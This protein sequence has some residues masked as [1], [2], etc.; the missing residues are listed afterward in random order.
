MVQI[1]FHY[2]PDV[3]REQMIGYE[4]AALIWGQ[5]FT[6]N[7]NVDIL[8]TTTNQLNENVIGG[9]SPQFHEQH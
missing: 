2:T 1:N 7:I 4:M 8:A 9:A 6:D 5:L 3:T